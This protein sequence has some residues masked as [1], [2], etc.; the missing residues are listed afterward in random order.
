M[1]NVEKLKDKIKES[2]MTIKAVSEKSGILRETLYNRFNI[3]ADFK[4][5]E[6]DSLTRV[7]HLSEKERNEIFL[8]T[9]VNLIHF[10]SKNL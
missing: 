5:S 8:P 7:L 9:K 10:F 4:A 6:I 2:G 3:N 1:T